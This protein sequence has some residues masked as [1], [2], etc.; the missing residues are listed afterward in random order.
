MRTSSPPP[1]AIVKKVA[2]A[3][4]ALPTSML[5]SINALAKS[6]NIPREVLASN[7]E[8]EYAWADLP[9]ELKEIPSD[10]RGELIARMCVAVSVGL[11]D[12]AMNYIWN[13]TILHLR[14]TIR[15]FGLSVVKQIL[16]RDFDEKDLLELQDS[17]L[18][19]LCLKLNLIN[20]D[21]FFFLDQCRDTRNN[22]SAAHPT[23]GKIND[24][25]FVVFLN[26]CVKYALAET[27]LH[28][29][30]DIFAFISA[31]KG[32]RFNSGQCTVWVER[33]NATHD[34]QRQ[35][36][37][38]MVHG[39]YCDPSTPEPSRLNSL[40]L[41]TELK[42][43]FSSR[44][45]SDLI[46]RHSEYLAKGD[47]KRHKASQQFFE[48]LSLIKLLNESEQHSIFSKAIENLWNAHQGMNNFYNEPPFAKR[49][50]EL[51]KQEEIPET[52]QDQYVG[53][54]VTCFIGNAYGVSWGAV[55]SYEEMIT[56]FSPKEI[57]T[58]IRL[59]RGDSPLAK[60]VNAHNECRKRFLDSLKL[61]DV[62]SVPAPVKS[63]YQNLLDEKKI[64]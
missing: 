53:V 22:F 10:H 13:A 60:R 59:S 8:I 36:L 54:V 21:G 45:R 33:L 38:S 28:K 44:I 35:L 62:K 32:E 42:D 48:K 52:A 39:I 14:D 15:N 3:L 29:G 9:R 31:I 20:E 55:P 5:S 2:P 37:I 46:N 16:Q 49:V 6:L 30:V 57:A 12:G 50:L 23:L 58:L 43:A 61:I 1:A 24:R 19:D 25:E 64:A 17:Q 11:F 56:G 40:D 4:P 27:A 26:R 47:E 18:L 51:S 7:E 41:C 63:Q 34:A